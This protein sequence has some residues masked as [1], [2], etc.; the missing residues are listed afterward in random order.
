MSTIA[1]IQLAEGEQ[2]VVK[3]K[4][5]ER[6]Q[7]TFTVSNIYG[8][9]LRM[10][11]KCQFEK[12]EQK[13]WAKT[14]APVERDIGDQGSEQ[15][16]IDIA[17]PKNATPGK[18][19]FQ[20]LVY[21][22]KD[23]NLD[24]TMSDPIVVDIPV[25][26][27]VVVPKKPLWPWVL[28]SVAALTVIGGVITWIMLA[29]GTKVPDLV[30]L[31]V[32][33]AIAK[34]KAE[35]LDG[36]IN[37]KMTGKTPVGQVIAQSPEAGTKFKKTEIKPVNL[38]VEAFS[39]AVPELKG[40]N[41]AQAG[42]KLKLEGL[43]LGAVTEKQTG[44]V[45]GGAVLNSEPAATER[46]APDAEVKLVIETRSVQV[47]NVAGQLLRD[48]TQQLD[49]LGLRNQV[50]SVHT[51]AEP[52]RVLSTKPG[53][54]T[55]VQQGAMVTL[56]VEKQM[57]TVPNLIGQN[58]TTAM[59]TLRRLNL[60]V[61]TVR[62]QRIFNMAPNSVLSHI[63]ASGAS[64]DAMTPVTLYVAQGIVPFPPYVKTQPFTNIQT[65]KSLEVL[66]REVPP[67]EPGK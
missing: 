2:R 44:S 8:T 67:L 5:A 46:V 25:P 45:A 48:A 31:P 52:L 9:P 1:T 30:G 59:D 53:A 57:V 19:S 40:M 36:I 3:V 22:L 21:S 28:A 63:P 4:P 47:P 42:D 27:P 10:G 14:R 35:G 11:I 18:Y 49:G 38:Q 12:A 66:R 41:L 65:L 32:D 64:V 62:Y 58:A 51:G 37:E 17:P 13:D 6:S 23:P 15:V 29:S 55:T 33:K 24:F 50:E 60:A 56:V 39:I 43:K 26:E 61:G 54:S 7:K 34:I 20:L 16:I